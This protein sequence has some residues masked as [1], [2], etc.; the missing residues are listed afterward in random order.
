MAG[1]Y[2]MLTVEGLEKYF[3]GF[4]PYWY[5]PKKKA[6]LL[7]TL[8]EQDFKN[9]YKYAKDYKCYPN[10]CLRIVYQYIQEQSIN[11]KKKKFIKRR[12]NSK[13]AKFQWSLHRQSH[14]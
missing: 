4:M 9:L 6:N 7:K 11:F 12:R 13:H 2:E 14:Q 5:N 8:E 10:I 1:N 3:I